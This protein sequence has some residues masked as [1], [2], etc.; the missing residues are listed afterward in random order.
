M[1]RA[2]DDSISPT[3]DAL[4]ELAQDSEA[5]QVA[6]IFLIRPIHDDLFGLD[7]QLLYRSRRFGITALFSR[8]S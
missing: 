7:L 3:S 6:K 8:N 4:L 1:A 5:L 2:I